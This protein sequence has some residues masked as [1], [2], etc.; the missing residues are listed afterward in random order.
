MK[1]FY[2]PVEFDSTNPV[3]GVVVKDGTEF[4]SFDCND[5]PE[6]ATFLFACDSPNLRKDEK[7]V[8]HRKIYNSSLLS[9]YAYFKI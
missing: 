9:E 5:V 4:I 6:G 7:D 1:T 8:I 2:L 3:K